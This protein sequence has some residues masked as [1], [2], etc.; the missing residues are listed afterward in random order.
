[1]KKIVA[2]TLILATLMSCKGKSGGDSGGSSESTPSKKSLFAKWETSDKSFA[3]D[4]SG[5][6]FDT[7]LTFYVNLPISQNWIDA[8]NSAGRDT[9]GLVAGQIYYCEL[10]IYF[11]GT[12][13]SGAFATDHDDIDTPAH[14]ACLEWDSNCY[15][16]VCNFSADHTYTR[17][18]DK[19]VFDYFGSA[20]SGSYGVDTLE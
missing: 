9:T 5:G 18:G 3:W 16:G 10:E 14:N 2:C 6:Q 17:S 15:T 7:L 8:L 13:D 20:D 19:M 4:F 1:M 12:E 11:T